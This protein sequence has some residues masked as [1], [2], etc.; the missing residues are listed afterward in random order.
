MCK[1]VPFLALPVS[2]EVTDPVGE[3]KEKIIQ[4]RSS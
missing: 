2:R 1:A 3:M 4:Q